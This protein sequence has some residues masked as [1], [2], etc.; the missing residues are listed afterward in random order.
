MHRLSKGSPS[1]NI[2]GSIT[3]HCLYSTGSRDTANKEFNGVM[4]SGMSTSMFSTTIKTS[5]PMVAWQLSTTIQISKMAVLVRD[6]PRCNSH[7]KT[8]AVDGPISAD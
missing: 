5:D 8:P 2:T 3:P 4:I 1:P 6:G 7:S